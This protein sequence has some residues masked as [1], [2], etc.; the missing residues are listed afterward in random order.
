M[1]LDIF[2]DCRPAFGW[3]FAAHQ[4]GAAAAAFGAGVSRTE[5][6]T[7]LPAL[8]VAG[9]AWVIAAALAPCVRPRRPWRRRETGLWV[10]NHGSRCSPQFA[11]EGDRKPERRGPRWGF[12][13][14]F[15]RKLAEAARRRKPRGRPFPLPQPPSSSR[16]RGG[17]RRGLRFVHRTVTRLHPEF[18]IPSQR[19]APDPPVC[20]TAK[21]PSRPRL[22]C[23]RVW[24][25]VSMGEALRRRRASTVKR[26]RRS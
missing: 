1:R 13:R 17:L 16:R 3:I 19:A 15:P 4:L 14:T 25:C 2:P 24:A 12:A 26:L 7:Y 22:D 9:V 8:H 21:R 11:R 10:A 5:L 6:S 20:R 18:V 23:A